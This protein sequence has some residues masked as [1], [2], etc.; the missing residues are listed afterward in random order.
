MDF[1][2]AGRSFWLLH[3]RLCCCLLSLTLSSWLYWRK[4][5]WIS[6]GIQTSCSIQRC[7]FGRRRTVCFCGFLLVVVCS[8]CSGLLSCFCHVEPPIT[9]V[10]APGAWVPSSFQAASEH[11]LLSG[12]PGSFC[13][14]CC[15]P[16][17][18]GGTGPSV[19]GA[20]VQVDYTMYWYFA[21]P[22]ADF[23][24]FRPDPLALVLAPGSYTLDVAAH[25]GLLQ[26]TVT[27]WQRQTKLPSVP[28]YNFQF[29]INVLNMWQA[30]LMPLS[31]SDLGIR[32]PL[33]QRDMDLWGF[34]S[35]L[36]S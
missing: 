21:F 13:P 5:T 6:P 30:W 19:T 27:H 24:E 34:C 23:S 31:T 32:I 29:I 4:T 9:S 25:L 11:F 2:D 3:L 17:Q 28:C 15:L 16:C 12:F 35:H 36:S 22:A 18:R 8:T 33:A 7:L 14:G 20:A 1:W 26:V 10:L